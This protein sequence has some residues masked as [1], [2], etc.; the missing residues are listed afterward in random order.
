MRPARQALLPRRQCQR[1]DA[2]YS[3]L[4]SRKAF[5]CNITAA[6]RPYTTHMAAL[7]ILYAESAQNSI[8]ACPTCLTPAPAG[9][10]FNRRLVAHHWV[11]YFVSRARAGS[12]ASDRA[13]YQHLARLRENAPAQHLLFLRAEA[14][15]SEI[16]RPMRRPFSWTAR[17]YSIYRCVHH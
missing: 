11:P 1:Q 13:P 6:L 4:R 2:A 12:A 17:R 5:A 3:A 9:K 16:A 7:A 15:E 8:Y 14:L 10:H